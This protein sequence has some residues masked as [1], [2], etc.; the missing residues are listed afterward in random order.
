MNVFGVTTARVIRRLPVDSSEVTA[1]TELSI[2]DVEGYIKDAAAAI[3]GLLAQAGVDPD[4]IDDVTEQQCAS[5]V[6]AKAVADSMDQMGASTA[7]GYG[8]YRQ[9]ADQVYNR[10]AARPQT[11][12]QQVTRAQYSGPKGKTLRRDFTGRNYEF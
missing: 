5:Y 11:L 4:S 3:H 1:T 6:E 9:R 8:I 12:N 2:D 10:L 7:P